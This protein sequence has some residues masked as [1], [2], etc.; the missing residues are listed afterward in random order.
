[1]KKQTIWVRP[2]PQ[3]DSAS[4]HGAGGRPAAAGLELI[5]MIGYGPLGMQPVFHPDPTV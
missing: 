2:C 5:T 4:V 1:M 3:A